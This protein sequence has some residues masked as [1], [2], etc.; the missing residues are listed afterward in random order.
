MTAAL[1]FGFRLKYLARYNKAERLLNKKY[2]D[3][4]SFSKYSDV[5]DT[6]AYISGVCNMFSSAFR[7]RERIQGASNEKQRYEIMCSEGSVRIIPRHSG[8]LIGNVS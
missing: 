7:V 3:I 5:H 6:Y 8:S 2:V 1:L 4:S